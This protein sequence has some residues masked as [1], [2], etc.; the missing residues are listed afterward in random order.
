MFCSP[1]RVQGFRC[2]L[3]RSL[4]PKSL[5]ALHL[6]GLPLPES[7][8][9]SSFN[10]SL[11]PALALESELR[12]SVSIASARV[13]AHALGNLA[14]LS[15]ALA[16]AAFTADRLRP[17]LRNSVASVPERSPECLPCL[18]EPW[19]AQEHEDLSFSWRMGELEVEEGEVD[20]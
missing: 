12:H 15:A 1:H 13:P 14:I 19:K 7:K 18:A 2:V 17:G 4:P 11:P 5:L 3:A 20:S 9:A 16:L 8:A 10:T 6:R